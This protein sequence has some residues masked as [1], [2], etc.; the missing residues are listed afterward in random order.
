[1]SN[2]FAG[3][4]TRKGV[5]A[6]HPLGRLVNVTNGIE[7]RRITFAVAYK[8]VDS[9]TGWKFCPKKFKLEASNGS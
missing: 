7:I 8:L 1:M 3:K 5:K 2:D 4:V 9:H 6:N